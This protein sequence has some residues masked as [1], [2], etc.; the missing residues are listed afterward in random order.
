MDD[1]TSGLPAANSKKRYGK[2]KKRKPRSAPPQE[3]PPRAEPVRQAPPTNDLPNREQV[4][5]MVAEMGLAGTV[6]HLMRTQGWDFKTA[7][8]WLGRIRRG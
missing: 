4:E 6:Q 2:K 5:R 3:L 1:P 7:A 8:G